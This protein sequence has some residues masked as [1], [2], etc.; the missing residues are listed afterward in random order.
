M[1]FLLLLLNL[2]SAACDYREY[3]KEEERREEF[4][5]RQKAD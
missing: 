5:D 4:R 1:K 3:P 2:L